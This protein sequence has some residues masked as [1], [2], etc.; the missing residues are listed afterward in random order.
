[1]SYPLTDIEG[2]DR[3]VAATLKSI[4][5]RSTE[6]LIE[7]ARTCRRRRALAKQTGLGEKQLLC[8]ANMA[9]RMRIPGVSK[10]HAALL[11]AAGVDTVRELKYRNPQNLAAAMKMANDKRKLVRLLPSEKVAARWI[12]RAKTLP[13]KITY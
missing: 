7:A 8:W 3:D 1:M 13:L 2:I 4:G 9:D 10:D 6:S 12:E 5:I 11:G